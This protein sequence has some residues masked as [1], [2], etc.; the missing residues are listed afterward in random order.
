MELW[1]ISNYADLKGIGG[2]RAS[3]RWHFAGQ[4]VVYL[5]EHPASALLEILVHQQLSHSEYVPDSYQLLRIKVP[6]ELAIAELQEADTPENWR[7]DMQWTQSAGTEWLA[8]GATAL[9]KVPSA[10][11]P[12]TN[13]LLNPAHPDAAR[14][15]IAEVL[16]VSHDRRILRLLSKD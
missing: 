12:A 15:E 10:I 6:D 2:L 7:A 13:F 4:P 8:G 11:L 1:R 3:G 9:L 5:A 14:L 16:Q